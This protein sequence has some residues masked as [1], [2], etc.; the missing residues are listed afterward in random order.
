LVNDKALHHHESCQFVTLHQKDAISAFYPALS[1]Q[2]N[3]TY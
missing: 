1:V 2:Q 3:I